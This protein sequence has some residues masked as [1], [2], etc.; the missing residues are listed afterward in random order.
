M[1]A[2]FPSHFFPT[3]DLGEFNIATSS[4]HALSNSMIMSRAEKPSPHSSPRMA[5]RSQTPSV[6]SLPSSISQQSDIYSAQLATLAAAQQPPPPLPPPPTTN[7]IPSAPSMQ[8]INGHQHVGTFN[9]GCH[10]SNCNNNSISSSSNSGG[11]SNS[12]SSNKTMPVNKSA[13]QPNRM[14]APTSSSSVN[15]A[16]HMQPI[17]KVLNKAL[18][19]DLHDL[20]QDQIAPPLPPRKSSPAGV[21]SDVVR[22]LKPQM[23]PPPQHISPPPLP[24]HTTSSVLS[25]NGDGGGGGG[26]NHQLS[27]S[28]ENIT[29]C[30]FDVPNSV[31]PPIPKHNV[32][33]PPLPA[34]MSHQLQNAAAV[35]NCSAVDDLDGVIV[36]PAETIIGLTTTGGTTINK[37]SV[38]LDKDPSDS[39]N[40]Y[41]LKNSSRLQSFTNSNNCSTAATIAMA[42]SRPSKS[43]TTPH[44]GTDGLGGSNSSPS[45][46]SSSST[47]GS[48]Q[49]R[50]DPQPQNCDGMLPLLY[51]NVTINNK[52]C[53]NSGSNSSSSGSSNNSCSSNVPYENINLEYIARLMKEGYSKEN[54]VT[55][56]GISRNNIEMACDILHEFVSKHGKH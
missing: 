21:A 28:S 7:Q 1:C 47:G 22:Q 15:T 3:Q 41:Q 38:S 50:S 25:P 44:F 8:S 36:G 55:A 48:N 19:V 12:I 37:S 32:V 35:A 53:S 13:A 17:N 6:C 2:H 39:N 16:N 10:N 29:F 30:A 24:Q 56:L 5:R 42:S 31:A 34:K 43:M 11:S 52:D 14:S 20:H 45:S 18:S 49:R 4:L 27:Q 51:E 46:S 26:G 23:A 54:V 40:L 9:G 33:S